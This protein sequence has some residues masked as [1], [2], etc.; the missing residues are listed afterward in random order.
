MKPAAAFRHQFQKDRVDK[1]QAHMGKM[2][3]KEKW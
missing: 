2:R 3:G 1:R